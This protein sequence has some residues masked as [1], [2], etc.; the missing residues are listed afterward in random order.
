[1]P[2]LLVDISKVE[3]EMCHRGLTV[4]A[5]HTVLISC[6]IVELKKGQTISVI[7]DGTSKGCTDQRT[8][9]PELATQKRFCHAVSGKSGGAA[10]IFNGSREARRNLF[11]LI[12]I[13]YKSFLERTNLPFPR[14][15]HYVQRYG[16][17][18]FGSS[19]ITNVS[20]DPCCCL[21]VA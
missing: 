9:L 10:H 5:P 6:M 18:M 17:K 13:P 8:V 12:P 7:F 1:M 11:K 20:L 14:D 3:V 15:E 16:S 21:L 2:V 4:R 19:E